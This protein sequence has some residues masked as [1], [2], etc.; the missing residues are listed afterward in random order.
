MEKLNY[1]ID[2]EELEMIKHKCR[3]NMFCYVR[4]EEIAEF[5]EEIVHR[6]LVKD[7]MDAKE[8]LGLFS[9]L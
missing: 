1:Q 4:R 7:L 9:K 5:T 8:R 6:I 3:S 2:E